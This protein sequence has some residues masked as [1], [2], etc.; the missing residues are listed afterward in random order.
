MWQGPERLSERVTYLA[1]M[2][3]SIIKTLCLSSCSFRFSFSFFE[4]GLS[5]FSSDDLVKALVFIEVE[6]S[7]D[8]M[9]ASAILCL[10]C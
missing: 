6:R 3:F 8:V 5:S 7:G 9:S 10:V 4:V 1:L 2:V